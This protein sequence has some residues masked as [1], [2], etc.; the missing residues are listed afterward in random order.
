MES[1]H[2]E[3]FTRVLIGS[4]GNTGFSVKIHMSSVNSYKTADQKC[5]VISPKKLH[6]V[7]LE[8]VSE[9][10]SYLGVS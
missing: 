10:Y 2:V 3:I 9:Y 8:K 5:Q 6:V 1:A 7:L 4:I